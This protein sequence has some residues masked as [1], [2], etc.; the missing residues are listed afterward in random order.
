MFGCH[1]NKLFC[2]NS[3]TIKERILEVFRKNNLNVNRASKVLGI[4]QRT[5]N[6]QINED[7]RVGMELLYAII[8]NFPEISIAWLLT[9]EGEMFRDDSDV[10]CKIPYFDDLPLSAGVRDMYDNFSEI[11][12]CHIVIPGQKADFYFPVKGESMEPE[13][14]EGDIVGVVRVSDLNKISP[15][16][17]YM[18]LTGESRM[19]KHCS[20]DPEDTGILWCI[21]PNYPT[22]SINKSD[23]SAIFRVV[24]R[25]QK[26]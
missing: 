24:S 15:E 8:D 14:Y 10:C 5:L 9:G 13:L 2:M 18:V 3:K 23:I 25:I 21:S 12:T 4:P 16:H 11:P 6:R 22:F 26:F 20:T 17:L 7:G 1:F 19:V